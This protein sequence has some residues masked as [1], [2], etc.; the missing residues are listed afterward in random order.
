[1]VSLDDADK[2]AAFAAS[3]GAEAIP[4]VSDPKGVA[5]K[6]YGVIG[7]GGLYSRRWT[8]Y[9]D[10]EGRIAEIDKQVSPATAGEDMVRQLKRLGFPKRTPAP[11]PGTTP[12]A[13]TP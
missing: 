8:F 6:A 11:L 2:N 10:P 12:S 1:M 4:V 5:A 3:L 9:I 13:A 7:M